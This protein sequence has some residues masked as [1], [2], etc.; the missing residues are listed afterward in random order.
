M[1]IFTRSKLQKFVLPK[2]NVKR[3]MVH[4]THPKSILSES[5]TQVVS[6]IWKTPVGRKGTKCQ[7]LSQ[8]SPLSQTNRNIDWCEENWQVVPYVLQ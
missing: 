8:T 1:Y 7:V 5:V 3:F 6:Q 2:Q 4:L